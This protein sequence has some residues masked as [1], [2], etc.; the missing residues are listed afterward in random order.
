MNSIFRLTEKWLNMRFL[1]N[2]NFPNPGIKILREAG[3]SVKS[4]SEGFSGMSDDEVVQIAVKENLIIL[5]F[6]SDYG[7]LIYK[8]SMKNPPAV[9][10]FRFKGLHP[11]YAAEI[12]IH[13]IESQQI[14]LKDRFTVIENDGIR[15]RKYFED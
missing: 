10:Y 12:L 4:I 1:A 15:Q 3:Y 11:N 14:Q 5:T 13:C 9:V 2:E 6:D 8:Y 7:E